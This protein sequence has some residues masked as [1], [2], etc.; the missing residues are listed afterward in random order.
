MSIY[1]SFCHI[2][3]V[4]QYIFY[5]TPATAT[6]IISAL[7][8]PPPQSPL[9]RPIFGFFVIFAKFSFFLTFYLSDDV[10]RHSTNFNH[11]YILIQLFAPEQTPNTEENYATKI[12]TLNPLKQ[13]PPYL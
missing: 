8:Q 7:N 10:A 12:T 4:A 6:P 2:S 13:P 5:D 9:L 3:N 1:P 11:I